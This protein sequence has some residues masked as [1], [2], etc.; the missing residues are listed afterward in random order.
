MYVCLV[1]QTDPGEIQSTD[2]TDG[3]REE[4]DSTII[5]IIIIITGH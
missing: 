3:V 1:V 2:G 5:I 4:S